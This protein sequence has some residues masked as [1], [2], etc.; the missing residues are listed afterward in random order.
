MV[1]LKILCHFLVGW[2]GGGGLNYYLQSVIRE[3]GFRNRRFFGDIIF[4]WLL[5]K[6]YLSSFD[7]I[8]QKQKCLSIILT[9]FALSRKM[10][11]SKRETLVQNLL[12][13][14]CIMLKN[15]QTCFKHIAELKLQDFWSMFRHFSRLPMKGVKGTSANVTY[16]IVTRFWPY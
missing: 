9:N 7:A 12:T 13:L 5:K 16:S 8:E 1:S 2:K 6:L 15:G 11:K 3:R 14:V 10:L 4:E